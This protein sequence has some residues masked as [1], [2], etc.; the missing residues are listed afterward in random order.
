[1]IIKVIYLG[2]DVEVIDQ[3]IKKNLKKVRDKGNK[4]HDRPLPLGSSAPPPC[5]TLTLDRSF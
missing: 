4:S 3:Q 1:M 2:D 5:G